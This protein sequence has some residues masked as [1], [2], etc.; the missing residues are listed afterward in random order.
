MTPRSSYTS[1]SL[2]IAAFNAWL[3]GRPAERFRWAKAAAVVHPAELEATAEA[4]RA[5]P[6]PWLGRAAARRRLA[7]L[8]GEPELAAFVAEGP[9]RTA[10]AMLK[11]QGL[12]AAADIL[13]AIAVAAYWG[14]PPTV[15]IVDGQVA[16]SIG[17]REILFGMPSLETLAGL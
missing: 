3:E 14:T 13:G 12:P 6:I 4:I 17:G 2:R 16:L 10:S 11:E 7:A 5:S 8:I 15:V 9:V 1:L